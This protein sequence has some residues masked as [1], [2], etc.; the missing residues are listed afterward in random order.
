MSVS[1]LFAGSPLPPLRKAHLFDLDVPLSL[2]CGG[3]A[4][5]K[6]SLNWGVD[7]YWFLNMFV[8]GW[9]APSRWQFHTFNNCRPPK[10]F[11][12]ACYFLLDH[13]VFQRKH[14]KTFSIIQSTDSRQQVR[15]RTIL[16]CQELHKLSWGRPFSSK[17]VTK[18][19]VV[20]WPLT[21]SKRTTRSGDP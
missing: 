6:Q 5:R 14:E 9:K 3:R 11:D 19:G 2:G 4:P 12:L 21:F 18:G 20:K 15:F 10:R 17:R 13:H 7:W 8:N 16:D 1:E